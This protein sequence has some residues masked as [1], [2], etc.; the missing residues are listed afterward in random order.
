MLHRIKPPRPD[1]H[2]LSSL[3][4][5]GN[6]GPKALM[7]WFIG[8]L[9]ERYA[10]QASDA[11]VS[12]EGL[13]RRIANDPAQRHLDPQDVLYAEL[14]S[15]ETSSQELAAHLKPQSPAFKLASLAAKR[16]LQASEALTST[17][18][19]LRGAILAHDANIDAIERARSGFATLAASDAR[20]L[21]EEISRAFGE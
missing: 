7:G 10:R 13:A 21:D 1:V 3:V 6:W 15:I 20:V 12:L 14:L 8:L 2:G 5:L 9:L 18:R 16:A 11:V 4:S 19:D 17:A